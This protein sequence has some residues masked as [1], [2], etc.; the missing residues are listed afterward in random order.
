MRNK[1][2]FRKK[3]SKDHMGIVE[4]LGEVRKRLFKIIIVFFI[5]S[6][7]SFNYV[8]KIVSILISNSKELGYSLVYLAPGELFSQYIKISLI[9]GICLS[10]PIILYQLWAFIKPGLKKGEKAVVFLS[11]LAG[12][13]CFIIG[14]SFAYILALPIMLNFFMTVDQNQLVT[15]TISI[16]SYINFIISTL[17]TFGIVFEMPVI[18]VLLSQLGLIRSEWLVKSRKVVIVLLFLIGALITPPEIVSQ[19][20]VALPM[21]L[22]FEISVLLSKLIGRRKQKRENEI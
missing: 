7:V 22:L 5:F 16:Q 6:M 4:H 21:L 12:L 14:A 1:K 2:K 20:L 18:T 13:L 3:S 10:S 11:L 9:I 19:I 8:D 15:P 17:L